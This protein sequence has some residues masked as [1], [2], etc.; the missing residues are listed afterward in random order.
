LE[1]VLK[2]EVVVASKWE[3]ISNI[4]Q[5]DPISVFVDDEAVELF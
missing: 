5:G 1:L 3:A 4:H 2:A